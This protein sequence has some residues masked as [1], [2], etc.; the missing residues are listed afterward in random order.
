MNN[1]FEKKNT[2]PKE[3]LV[4]LQEIDN[5]IK[6]LWEYFED[7]Y[8]TEHSLFLLNTQT[9]KKWL[10]VLELVE[11]LNILPIKL[12][13]DGNVIE[14][15]DPLA[16]KL[17]VDDSLE[18]SRVNI[19]VFLKSWNIHKEYVKIANRYRSLID[20]T[21]NKFQSGNTV[22]WLDD[23]S[24]K[25][26][27]NCSFFRD[28]YNIDKGFFYETNEVLLSARRKMHDALNRIGDVLNKIQYAITLKLPGCCVGLN[29]FAE[30]I[31]D[32]V[33]LY[34]IHH[35]KDYREYLREELAC[36]NLGSDDD[37]N[38]WDKLLD[39]QIDAIRLGIE[40]KF[41]NYRNG[42]SQE[43][44]HRAQNKYMTFDDRTRKKMD[45]NCSML[46]AFQKKTRRRHLFD[47]EKAFDIH[48]SP[49]LHLDDKNY[50]INANLYCHL[51]EE[52]FDLFVMLVLRW[53]I[54]LTE[55]SPEL[56]VEY[57]QWIKSR[58]TTDE[59][60][61][62]LSHERQII[63]DA[64]IKYINKGEWK[65]PATVENVKKFMHVVLGQEPSL[66]PPHDIQMPEK[67]WKLL[68]RGR[69]S[70]NKDANTR[71]EITWAKIAGL[72]YSEGLLEG[73][74]DGIMKRFF[75]ELKNLKSPFSKGK[76][77]DDKGYKEIQPF[78][79]KYIEKIIKT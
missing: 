29:V 67:L 8:Q 1:Q 72:F 22:A 62:V 54:I 66:L 42:M 2:N 43:E 26:F 68:E 31:K 45:A 23:E 34:A 56:K 77:P 7:N 28:F 3:N 30:N 5:S 79:E 9:L 38:I 15:F 16:Q 52:N 69:T 78:L 40:G 10:K 37:K 32:Y 48:S 60:P 24:L 4:L 61:S 41:Y 73:Q 50:D 25:F 35:E 65:A 46:M 76:K 51:N 58:K 49:Y 13:E 53:N 55:I 33:R 11:K 57:G 12:V 71:V 74:P 64:V 63:Y 75:G 6:D 44:Q 18:L 39:N 21:I 59:Y 27:E 47:F 70:T 36:N 19:L 20:D 17:V 14:V